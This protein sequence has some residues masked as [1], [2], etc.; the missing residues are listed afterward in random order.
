MLYLQTSNI[1]DDILIS[2]SQLSLGAL[3]PEFG[4][5]WRLIDALDPLAIWDTLAAAMSLDVKLSKEI[6]EE[7]ESSLAFQGMSLFPIFRS[8][9]PA[10]RKNSILTQFSEYSY[11]NP[12]PAPIIASTPI[13]WEQSIITGHPTHPMHRTRLSYP[14]IERLGANDQTEEILKRPRVRSRSILTHSA[15]LSYPPRRSHYLDPL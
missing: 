6:K 4:D 13:E 9:S 15:P 8:L 12:P 1:A 2:S 11:L 10:P 7:L 3:L 5:E 14:P